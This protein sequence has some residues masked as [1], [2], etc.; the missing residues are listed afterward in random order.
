MIVVVPKPVDPGMIVAMSD[1]SLF[2]MP[3][4]KPET[5]LERR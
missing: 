2:K 3:C 5:R 4:I 1:T